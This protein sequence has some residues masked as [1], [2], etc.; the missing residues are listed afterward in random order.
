MLHYVALHYNTLHYNP[1][2]YV[3]LQYVAI[4][5]TTLQYVAQEGTRITRGGEKFARL[6]QE[7]RSRPAHGHAREGGA[8]RQINA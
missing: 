8:G 2:P 3:A 6:T 1:L 5:Y 4:R 7:A